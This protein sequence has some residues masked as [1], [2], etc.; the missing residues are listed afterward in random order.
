[1]ADLLNEAD[2]TVDYLV[3]GMIQ[4]GSVNAI[5]A[6]PKVGK[7]TLVRELAVAV[8]RGEEF[9]GRRCPTAGTVWYLAFEGRRQ[10][11]KTHFRQLG[12]RAT[13]P[14]NTFVGQAWTAL[15]GRL[16]RSQ[17]VAEHV[18]KVRASWLADGY[19]PK[20]VN[21]RVQTLQHLYRT[22][23]GSRAATP[24]DDVKPLPVPPSQKVLVPAKVFK[25]SRRT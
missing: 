8:G 23:D 3:D 20:T 6:K 22:L 19:S 13:D 25:T 2:E 9:I 12:A 24:A 5:S 16:R 4:R 15:Y 1:M 11:I 10:D 14:I 18:R 17:I 7:S 21:N